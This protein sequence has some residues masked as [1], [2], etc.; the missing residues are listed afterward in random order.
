M[1]NVKSW[2]KSNFGQ[3]K[4]VEYRDSVKQLVEAKSSEEYLALKDDVE[5]DWDEEFRNYFNKNVDNELL[6]NF[7]QLDSNKFPVFA[8]K[9][10][11][12]NLSEVFNSSFKRVFK[13]PILERTEHVINA[14]FM[15]QASRIQ[16][17]DLALEDGGKFLIKPD[18]LH[19]AVK[20]KL[21][22]K[23]LNFDL[24]L[25]Q[26]K[27]DIAN[28]DPKVIDSRSDNYSSKQMAKYALTNKTIEYCNVNKCWI[29][30]H[31]FYP[32]QQCIVNVFPDGKF[33]CICQFKDKQD[34]FHIIATK[35][36]TGHKDKIKESYPIPKLGIITRNYTREA[37]GSKKS[38]RVLDLDE[39]DRQPLIQIKK[40][41][42][43]ENSS[44][45]CSA[46]NCTKGV[47]I[48]TSLVTTK[49]ESSV[50]EN[51]P[52]V[53]DDSKKQL[54]TEKLGGLTEW[55][56]DDHI[57]AYIRYMILVSGV[58]NSFGLIQT[59]FVQ[60]F[61]KHWKENKISN[62]FIQH[63][64]EFDLI[65]KQIIFAAVN[66]DD[67]VS[68]DSKNEKGTHWILCAIML[69]L[70]KVYLIDSLDSTNNHQKVADYCVAIALTIEH[71]YYTK[72]R[73][74]WGV[75]I[76]KDFPKQ[77]NKYDCGVHVCM[78]A[79]DIVNKNFRTSL[80]SLECRFNIAKAVDR[81]LKWSETF[82]GRTSTPSFNKIKK[83]MQNI[84]LQS[85]TLG[86]QFFEFFFDQYITNA[87]CYDCGK[88]IEHETFY[89]CFNCYQCIHRKCTF[90]FANTKFFVCGN[91]S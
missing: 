28:D 49:T 21:P 67:S 80:D 3:Q 26:A 13:V 17:F 22:F 31:P 30:G 2:A 69:A 81:K 10:I 63:A 46:L 71:S 38:P 6:K 79:E 84:N 34:C 82:I 83:I 44:V 43:Q 8:N 40:K 73:L 90:H 87:N 24:L 47:A 88:A 60:C 41:A 59:S 51:V 25:E 23:Q 50:K 29:V 86:Q 9:A 18:C 85:D 48:E 91:C 12:N 54:V 27:N 32:G 75:H 58:S 5:N 77:M 45:N 1:T 39:I 36:Q 35:L 11:T 64:E 65:N 57:E 33:K 72:E 19:D 42:K 37:R 61:V 55:L 52:I 15:Y 66:T 7:Q 14:L 62:Q 20:S 76:A 4:A 16:E 53:F 56:F 78:N 70:K 74:L 89:R 68:F